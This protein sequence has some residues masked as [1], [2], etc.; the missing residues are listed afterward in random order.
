MSNPLPMKAVLVSAPKY[1]LGT[2]YYVWKQSRHNREVPS[3]SLLECILHRGL[4]WKKG[5]HYGGTS[6]ELI[7]V[8]DG[9]EVLG[10]GTAPTELYGLTVGYQE[11]VYK[12]ACHIR[13]EIEMILHE[14]I[15]VVENLQ[16]V[17]HLQNI[18]ISLREQ[19]VR[20]RIG[21]TLDPRVGADIV[22]E[23]LSPLAGMMQD[24]P[25]G[26]LMHMQ[27]V[28][29]LAESTWWSQTSRVI[30][31]TDMYSSGRY[32]VPEGLKGKRVSDSRL[33]QTMT[34]WEDEP[35]LWEDEA[36]ALDLDPET[37]DFDAEEY[38]KNTIRLLQHRYRRMVEAGIHIEDA[39]QIIPVGATHGIT[40]G[41]NLKAMLHIFG[42]RSSWIAQ[43]GI[44]GDIMGQMADELVKH[45][46]PMFRI[47]LLPQCIK[48]GKYVGCPVN[49]TNA[50]RVAG[51]DGMPPCPIWVRYQTNDAVTAVVDTYAGKFPG[52]TE[53]AW[54]PPYIEDRVGFDGP[55]ESD[56]SPLTPELTLWTTDRPVEK[57]MLDRT[58][59]KYSKLWGFNVLEGIP[60]EIA[61]V[62]TGGKDGNAGTK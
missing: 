30:P 37:E 27:I 59:T 26:S 19:L 8:L 14:G 15:P 41:I 24:A 40:W 43:I 29:D 1:P 10:F 36:G 50:E 3:P 57:E 53:P 5:Y 4:S 25:Q 31:F 49:G 7:Q 9:C 51:V 22:P 16:F 62:S 47:V 28:P 11:V 35:G 12:A 34:P 52:R 13:D 20:H 60:E 48:R 46:H 55:P 58:A 17:F 54:K 56:L 38:Y 44:W 18:P 33:M 6:E 23:P 42:K 45:V 39:R 61:T 2:L 21:V 32:F